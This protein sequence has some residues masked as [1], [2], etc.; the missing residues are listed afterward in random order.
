LHPELQRLGV[1]VVCLE[2]RR[3]RAAKSEAT[4]RRFTAIS[5][6]GPITAHSF[7]S[8]MEDPTVTDQENDAWIATKVQRLS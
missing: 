4:G 2:T 3:V 6:V 8:A 5:G 7:S 1:Q